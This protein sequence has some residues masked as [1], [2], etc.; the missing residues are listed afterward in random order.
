M[1]KT[2]TCGDCIHADICKELNDGFSPENIAYCTAFKESTTGMYESPIKIIESAIDSISKSLI[3]DKEDAIILEV[4]RQLGVDV[5][6]SELLAALQYDRHQYDKGYVDGYEAGRPKW[7][8]VTER[9]PE[10]M[11]DVLCW[12]EYFRYGNYNRMYQTY[13]IGHYFR[14]GM[15]GGEV[16]NGHQTNVLAWIP[17]PE[18]PKGE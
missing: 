7:I 10:P 14:E 12:Y 13:G 18:P 17:L 2:K 4:K 16:S 8:P 11:V 6:R 5:D 9:L 15:W 3:R 1:T